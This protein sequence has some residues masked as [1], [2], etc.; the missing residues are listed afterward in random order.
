MIFS[1]NIRHEFVKNFQGVTVCLL[2]GLLLLAGSRAAR[3][4]NPNPPDKPVKLI[5]IHHSCGENWLSD[6]HGRLGI[7]LGKSNYFVSDTNY[8][9][10]P[11]SIG[12]RTDIVNWPEWF[13]E[14]NA[15]RFLNALYGENNRHSE[16]SRNQKDPGGPNRIIMFKS[17]FPNSDLEGRPGDPPARGDGLTVGNAKA[18]YRQLLYYFKTRPDKLFIAVTAPPLLDK[19][20]SANARAFNRWL[21]KDW[22]TGYQG[23]NVAVFDFYNVLTGPE[24]HHRYQNGKIEYISDRGRNTLYYPTGSDEHPSATGNRKATTEFVRLLNVYYHRW[25]KNR[26]TVVS[27]SEESS[28]AVESEQRAPV[29]EPPE[30]TEAATHQP[31]Q[32][33]APKPPSGN[34]IANF[35]NVPLDWVVFSDE[36]KDTRLVFGRDTGFAH[37]SEAGLKIEYDIAPDS[38]ATCSLVYSSPQNWQ[39]RSGVVLYLHAGQIGQEV[40]VVVYNGTSSD[41]LGHFEFIVQI[42]KEGVD[43]WQRVEMP[44]GKLA[45]PPWEGDGSTRFDPSR[46][47]GMAFAFSADDNSRKKGSVWI[48]DIGFLSK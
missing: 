35:E 6:A 17:C 2:T 8:G 26:P 10:G 34:V 21:V 31:D 18:I 30:Q 37:N 20:H 39:G 46:T 42:G 4:D 16:Y 23:S 45:Q 29:T 36:G 14:G 22:L 43:G 15:E 47:M 27:I 12:D 11:D 38:W 9:W 41:R 44:W 32:G 33:A 7:A 1:R 5:F 3:A 24:N 19:T 28:T 25:I 40:T 48:D 13:T